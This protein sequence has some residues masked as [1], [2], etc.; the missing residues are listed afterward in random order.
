M[1]RLASLAAIG[2]AFTIN[3][4]SVDSDNILVSGM[5]ADINAST[6]GTGSTRVRTTLFLE[7]PSI[8]NYIELEGG[9]LLTAYGPDGDRQ[10]MRE[11]QFLE[12]TSYRADFD[13]DDGG[14]EFIVEFSRDVD[15]GAPDSRVYLPLSFDIL[16]TPSESYSRVDDDI[17][18]DWD[19]ADT[20]EDVDLEFTGNCIDTEIRSVDGDP[21]TFV[22]PA[23][24]LQKRAGE[25]VDDVCDLDVT[26]VKSTPGD[27]DPNYGHGG[28][29]SGEQVRSL[30]LATEP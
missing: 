12:A 29:I 11:F 17:I 18:I 21:G 5:Y 23:G 1:N 8:T 26:I 2:A 3:C 9:D 6:D 13:V 7:N 24:S 4:Q 14:A 27:L 28:V 20:G 22:L 30:T 10:I 16:T 19:P 15:A 25:M